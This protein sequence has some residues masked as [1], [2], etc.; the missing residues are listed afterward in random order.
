MAAATYRTCETRYGQRYVTNMFG[1]SPL[2]TSKFEQKQLKGDA[3]KTPAGPDRRDVSGAAHFVRSS[4][5][6]PVGQSSTLS[7]GMPS[8]SSIYHKRRTPNRAIL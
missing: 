7:P 5:L 3:K 4:V 6:W 8:F 1:S 2:H